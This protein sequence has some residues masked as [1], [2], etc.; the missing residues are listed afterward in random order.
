MSD[1]TTGNI[2]Y[3]TGY[4][5][6]SS[7]G[8]FTASQGQYAGYVVLSWKAV[9]GITN[10]RIYRSTTVSGNPIELANV[11]NNTIYTDASTVSGVHYYY[12]I[13]SVGDMC[14]SK[15]GDYAMGYAQ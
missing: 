8:S 6:V 9:D 14:T 3:D 11:S 5:I 15:M 12:W 10:Y 4:K 1:G 2:G 13:L 7:P